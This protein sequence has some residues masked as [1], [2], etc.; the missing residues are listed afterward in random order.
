MGA[1][2]E[3]FGSPAR[4]AREPQAAAGAAGV[5]LSLGA[6]LTGR[7]LLVGFLGAS[8]MSM[9]APRLSKLPPAG[10]GKRKPCTGLS[11]SSRRA[12]QVLVSKLKVSSVQ[13][14]LF[15]T[16]TYPRKFPDGVRAKRDLDAF[17]KRLRRA[18]PS[19]AGI[20]KM[21]PQKR[22]APHFHLILLGVDFIEH[23]WIAKAWYEV[24]GSGDIRHYAA[25]TEVRRVK[26]YQH[27]VHYVS[28]YIAKET[29]VGGDA[30]G[31]GLGEV[32]RRWGHF[33]DW[34]AHLGEIAKFALTAKEAARL[35]RVLDMKRLSQARSRVKPAARGRAIRKARRRRALTFSQYW[36]GSPDFVLSQLLIIIGRQ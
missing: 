10:G 31:D 35:A 14:G 19:I 27:A 32:G 8:Y 15:V 4:P 34:R 26:S 25:G 2:S 20:W 23:E 30:A 13:K 18:F 7:F 9:R 6:N 1:E 3:S 24:V 22:G 28:K 11:K 16:L 33:G 29:A 36:L 17:I 21:E 5:G 12:M